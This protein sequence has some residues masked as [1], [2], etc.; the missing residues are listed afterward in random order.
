MRSV[1][2]NS[3]KHILLIEDVENCQGSSTSQG[4]ASKGGT[5]GTR[6]KQIRRLFAGP[7]RTDRKPASETFCHTDGI[8]PDAA[9]LEGKETAGS[10]DPALDLVQDHE[11]VV[12]IA[13]TSD[14]D[15][16]FGMTRQDAALALDGLQKNGRCIRIDETFKARKV[17]ELAKRKTTEERAEAFLDFLLRC[18][19]HSPKC[20][21]V[22]SAL[23]AN[24]SKARS[25]FTRFPPTV[26]A[27][28]LEQGFIGFGATVT[29]KDPARTGFL[30][31]ALGELTLQGIAKEVTHMDQFTG[32]PPNGLNPMRMPVTKGSHRDAGSEIKKSPTAII[33]DM[34]TLAAHQGQRDTI[35]VLYDILVVDRSRHAFGLRRGR[36]GIWIH[37]IIGLRSGSAVDDF[38]ADPLIGEDLEQ[39]AVRHPAV[40]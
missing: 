34:R 10:T 15:Q 38:C 31:K 30:G 29:E 22:E 3:L 6:G 39:G 13:K 33:P 2:T 7:D 19:T 11:E 1:L 21:T 40:D 20:P 36:Q 24:H 37:V 26:K 12:F 5:M 4:G 25:F 28:Q 17:V 9:V 14:S 35:V 27:G 16:E 23:G 18:G 32:L 8:W